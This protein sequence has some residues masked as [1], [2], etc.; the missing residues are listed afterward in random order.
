MDKK[1]ITIF[2]KNDGKNHK[3][4]L[5]GT[6]EDLSK[7]WCRTVI[8]EKTGQ[9]LDV[10]A[11]LVDY[12]LKELEYR[13]MLFHQVE[14]IGFNHPDGRRCYLRSLCFVLQNAIRELYPDKVLVVDHSL[15]SGLYCEIHETT[16]LEDGRKQSYFVTDDELD[17]IKEKMKE[18]IARNLP[19]KR[20]KTNSEEAMEIF[21]RNNQPL[22]AE[23]QKSIGTFICSVYYLD[24]NAD[25][26]HGPLIPSTG[27]LKTFDITAIG[28]GFCLQ[29]PQMTDFN[30]V[31]PMKRQA[32]IGSTL[33][34]HSDWCSII[35]IESLG[36]LNSAIKE[37]KAIEI[38]NLSEALHER[39]YAKIADKIK[40]SYKRIVMIAGPSS[41]GKTSSSLR[42]ALQ[43][44]VLGLKPKVI[45]LDNYFVDR[46]KTPKD[47]DGK[48]DF[49][50]LYA[51]D[52]DLLNS[53]LND[54][55]DGKEVEIPKYDFKTGSRTYTGN[56]LHLEDKDIL[57]LEGIH[58]LNPELTSAVDQSK[59]FRVFASALTSLNI[60]ENNNLS[61]SDNRLL[62]RMVRDNRVR[63]ISPEDTILRWN[64][65]RRG[66]SRN[67]F[68]YQ[69]NADAL[70]NSALIFELPML[71]Y[72]AEPLL[73]RISPSSPAYTE[74][75]RLLKFLDYII[76]LQPSEIEA[77]PP[78][79]I[80]REFIGGQTL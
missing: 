47:E 56:R 22:K 21:R 16:K 35:G 8:D 51:M 41:S 3:I 32:K 49:E 24:G 54:L 2:C 18:I 68:P 10:I 79:S 29:G 5:G 60:D 26:F 76:A 28:D 80:M 75:V 61:T 19:F 4:E 65:V 71:K 63:G 20:V 58:A 40:E 66:E 43:C 77:I 38:I 62:R 15:P 78:T 44:K 67:I 9:K 33:K 70:F 74:T 1:E 72:Y 25:S 42:I 30:K 52:L 39:N 55:L 69:E 46:D 36:N 45:E 11:A 53:Q 64:S 6:L 31:M 50:S 59:I 23:L 17:M 73:R 12:K 14:F 34:D 27:F 37:G 7:K 13:P 48:Y 57:I